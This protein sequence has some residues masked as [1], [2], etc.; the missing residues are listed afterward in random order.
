MTTRELLV[1]G[2]YPDWDMTAMNAEYTMHHV[3]SDTAA[4]ALP[5]ALLERVE[6]IAVKFHTLPESLMAAMPSL[7]V[8]ANYG[9]G[10][11]NID[12][13]AATARGIAVT[14]TPDVLSDEVADLAVGMLIA[15]ARRL[16]EAEAW[17]TEGR[18]SRDG[19]FPLQMRVWGKRAGIVGLGRIGREI[20][21]RLVA[22]KMD[23]SYYARTPKERPGWRHY[24]SVDALAADVDFLIVALAGGPE[25]QGLV[26]EAAL[27][28]LGPEGIVVNISRGST[29]DEAAMIEA[30]R[31]KALGGAALDVFENE[32][33]IDPRF[34][35]LENVLLQPHQASATR[36]TRAAMGALQ[37]ENVAAYF[38][39]TSLKTPVN[40]PAE[41][42]GRSTT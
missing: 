28:A 12:I 19:A 2:T 32:P 40:P 6:A 20:A 34:L 21:D 24:D 33:N 22:F 18:W 36:D 15:Q 4:A 16:V 37:R 27:H 17:V 25:T 5:T 38:A 41:A 23:I 3:E 42:F 31:T 13:P 39:G 29:I 30:L 1:I 11:D 8:I 7:R 26:G 10:F 35:T 14:N 9:V